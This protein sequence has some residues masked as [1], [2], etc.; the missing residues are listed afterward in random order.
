MARTSLLALSP[1]LVHEGERLLHEQ[2]SLWGADVRRAEGNLLLEYGF[3]RYRPPKEINGCSQ[4]ILNLDGSRRVCL[5]GFGL[6]YGGRRGIHLGRYDFAPRLATLK[7][8]VW[9][10]AQLNAGPLLSGIVLLEKAVRWIASYERWVDE[11]CGSSY[12]SACVH[13]EWEELAEELRT[14]RTLTR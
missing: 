1:Q 2:C 11:R 5:W 3:E 10:P 9:T 4:Y 6:F 7:T 14:L 8:N 12:R 13:L